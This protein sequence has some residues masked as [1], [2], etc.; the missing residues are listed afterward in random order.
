LTDWGTVAVVAVL[1]PVDALAVGYMTAW[2]F[3]RRVVK[4]WNAKEQQK[5]KWPWQR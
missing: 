3:A 1:M 5:K 4:A 2:F